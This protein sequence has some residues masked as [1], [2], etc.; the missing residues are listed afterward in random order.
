[1]EERERSDGQ[2]GGGRASVPDGGE[3]NESA[4]ELGLQRVIGLSS[5]F[6]RLQPEVGETTSIR[7][8]ALAF[9]SFNSNGGI[10]VRQKNKEN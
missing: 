5:S 1:M 10:E 8:A 4:R 2:P 6:S 7:F 3:E 9:Y